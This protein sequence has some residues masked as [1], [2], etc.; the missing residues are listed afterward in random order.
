MPNPQT[1][2]RQHAIGGAIGVLLLVFALVYRFFPSALKVEPTM[3]KSRPAA[4]ARGPAGTRP[5][6]RQLT[7]AESEL[8]AGPPISLAPA[9]VIAA[10]A[11]EGALGAQSG[12]GKVAQ[13]LTQAGAAAVNG[14][15]VGPG[16]DTALAL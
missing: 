4:V 2:T 13:L 16:D 14:R 15:L 10:R 11:R 7:P 5:A 12:K 9:G 8:N 1:V 3:L 6:P